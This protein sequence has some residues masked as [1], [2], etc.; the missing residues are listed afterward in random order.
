MPLR[1]RATPE[2]PGVRRIMVGTDLSPT[3]ERA[4]AWAVDMAVRYDAELILVRVVVNG[5]A[6]AAAESELRDYAADIAP[7]ARGVVA[8]GDD[9]AE[10][11]VAAIDEHGADVVVVGSVGMRGRRQFLLGNVPNRVSHAAGCTVVIV[12]TA[13]DA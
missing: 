13:G 7:G 8:T 11:I 3:A 5:T 4:V 9:P 2:Q 12:N 1:R 10:A 6:A